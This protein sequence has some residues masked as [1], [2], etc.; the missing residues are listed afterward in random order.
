MESQFFRVFN[1]TEEHTFGQEYAID[2]RSYAFRID[3]RIVD[4]DHSAFT[5]A[6]IA[7]TRFGMIA[8]YMGR[9]VFEMKEEIKVR[10]IRSIA[11]CEEIKFRDI[12]TLVV[13]PRIEGKT[14]P[15]D[16]LVPPDENRIAH[17]CLYDTMP[18]IVRRLLSADVRQ[19]GDVNMGH[20]LATLG[21]GGR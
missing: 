17:V 16:D 1:A 14:R 12:P 11:G 20:R 6:G 5:L 15:H 18:T 8:E 3:K 10:E 4:S 2:P 7:L 21:L 13:L 19:T 9:N